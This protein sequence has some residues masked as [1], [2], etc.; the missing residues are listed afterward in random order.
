MKLKISL[1]VQ[2]SQYLGEMIDSLIK[3]TRDIFLMRFTPTDR[4]LNT[5]RSALHK[6]SDNLG[7]TWNRI[8][9]ENTGTGL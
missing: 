5:D 3:E 2:V 7:M 8:F 6:M 9:T 1:G 4:L